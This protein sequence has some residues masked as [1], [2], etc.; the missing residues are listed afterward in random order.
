MMESNNGKRSFNCVDSPWIPVQNYGLVSLR[1]IFENES[2]SAIGGTPI[3]KIA[4]FKLLL[5][6]A[7]SAC[8]PK[9]EEEWN[10]LG[11]AAFK[12]KCLSYLDKWHDAFDLYGSQP[13]LQMPGIAKAKIV[14]FADLD[15][16][17][18]SGNTTFLTELQISFDISDADKAL[19][20]LCQMAFA[21]AGKKADNRVVLGRNYLG[22]TN[23]K[24]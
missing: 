15:P 6:V 23:P 24:G 20:L 21:A 17:K 19:L 22:K 1:A 8:T 14:S 3:Q 11:I 10:H 18:A 9:D 4:L 2:L 12:Q 16:Q 13:F 7:Q 5:A